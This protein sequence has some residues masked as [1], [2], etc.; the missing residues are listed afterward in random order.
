MT[1]TVPGFIAWP[2]IIAMAVLLAARFRWCRTNLY[3]RYYSNLMAWIMLIQ[4]LRE[5]DVEVML[6]KWAL[7]TVITA[8][9]LS[10]AAMIFAA[11]EFIGFTMLWTRLSPVE[12]RRGHRYY[13]LAAVILCV[14]YLAAATRARVAGQSLEVAGGWD[15]VLAC[16]FY[17]A[18]ILLLAARAIWMFAAELRKSTQK[19]D[20][21]LAVGGLL[22][23]VLTAAA[24]LEALVSAATDQLGWT[25]TLRFRL[26][27]HGFE[28]FWMAVIVYGF[29]AVPLVARVLRYLGLDPTSRSWNNL[30]A[31]RAS[32]TTVVPE[33]SFNLD[34]ENY[35]FQ[36]TT[37]QLHQTIIEIRD[38][39]LH[40]RPYFRDIAPHELARFLRANSVPTAEHDAA[41]QTLQLAHAARAKTAGATPGSPDV[42]TILRSRATTLDEEVTELLALAKW[43]KPAFAA[44]EQFSQIAPEV[45][46]SSPT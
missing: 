19:R 22:V 20:L 18:M 21:F 42:A 6:S 7:L 35:R 14:A 26:W 17:T 28:A 30:A 37:L 11:T 38:A 2:V 4:L 16:S 45:Q 41:S 43:W 10:S 46:A 25:D 32:L 34:H 40:L 39:I 29:G 33:S 8:Q 5:H 27:L 23:G 12:T 1:S 9:Q 13:R 15:G 36:K 44:T 31:L 3:E 24:C